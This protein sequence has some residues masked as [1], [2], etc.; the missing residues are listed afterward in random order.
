MNWTEIVGFLLRERFY[1]GLQ[2]LEDV[3]CCVMDRLA[4]GNEC[5]LAIIDIIQKTCLL[6]MGTPDLYG[7]LA[8]AYCSSYRL[9]GRL[10]RVDISAAKRTFS[11]TLKVLI[12]YIL[13]F[14]VV[15][16]RVVCLNI[17]MGLPN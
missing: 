10:E 7:K 11:N 16:I 14:S 13:G 12:L 15:I 6:S 5:G 8:T 1:L 2:S 3:A 4:F 9:T 17:A